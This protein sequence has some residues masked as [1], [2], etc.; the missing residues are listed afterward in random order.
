MGSNDV[1]DGAKT[2]AKI[3]PYSLV[4]NVTDNKELLHALRLEER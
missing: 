2:N 4:S 3:T 1:H